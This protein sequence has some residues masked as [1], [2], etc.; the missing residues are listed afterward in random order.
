VE[1]GGEGLRTQEAE[2]APPTGLNLR[3]VDLTASCE[4]TTL[5]LSA[6]VRNLG[7]SGIAASR[8]GIYAGHPAK[9]GTLLGSVEVPWLYGGEQLAFHRTFTVPEGT[10]RVTVVADDDRLFPEDDEDDNVATFTLSSACATNP[11]PVARCQDVTVPADASC[12]ATASV[13]SGSYDPNAGPG[14]FS[15]NQSPEGPYTAGAT[16]VQL[17]VSDGEAS[18]TC[19]ATVTVVDVTAPVPGASKGL[20]LAASAVSGYV[21]VG[22]ADCALP[23]SDNCGGSLDLGASGTL[24]RVTSDEAEDALSLA[25]LRTCEDIQVSADGKSALVRAEA[26]LLGNGRVYT[27]TYAVSDAAGNASTGTCQVSVPALLGNVVDSGPAYCQ[28]TGCPA[29]TG[30]GLLCAL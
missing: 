10:T 12:Q 27:F 17:T 6:A 13:D 18:S 28:G 29:G 14:A 3:T 8:A 5:S 25:R 30:S 11:A 15:V 22:L 16:P 4:A 1:P 7:V 21:R 26:A 24:L 2:A 19:S 9:D 20:V 23:A